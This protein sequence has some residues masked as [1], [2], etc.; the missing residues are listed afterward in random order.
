MQI[1]AKIAEIQEKKLV[2]KRL[3][4]SFS[5]NR[6]VELW[7]SFMPLL[8]EIANNIS[9]DLISLQI[10]PTDYFSDL[11]PNLEFEKWALTE[12]SN[13]DQIPENMESFVLQ[14]GLYA[15]FGYKGSSADKRIFQTIFT[16]WL[17]NSEYKLDTRP[18]FEVLGEKY[19]NNDPESEEEIWIPV[20][21]K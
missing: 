12:V 13:F 19:K 7:K 1:Q 10:Y 5:N 20:K 4:M 17:P 3:M 6:T 15:V 2:G 11:N 8:K 9:T 16:S 14:G 18:H 21:K